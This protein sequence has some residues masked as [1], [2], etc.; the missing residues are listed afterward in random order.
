MIHMK[1]RMNPA[2]IGL[3]AF[4]LAAAGVIALTGPASS[5]VFAS[6]GGGGG[7]SGG[8][9]GGAGGG[10]GS[11]GGG[12]SGGGSGSGH[13]GSGS[14]GGGSA[15]D[16]PMVCKKGSVYS[17]KK[18]TC[19]QASSGLIDDKELY[20]EGRD[21]ALAGHYDEA[22]TALDAVKTPDSMALTMIGY[23][24]RKLGNYEAGLAYYQKA[25][26]LDPGNVNT[27]EYLG[28]AYA[29]KGKLDLAK[30]ELIKVSAVC[31][32]SCEQYEDLAK[33]IDDK[34]AE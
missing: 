4:A 23:A 33:A 32:T 28:E 17:K 27:H 9:G 18:A 13:S 29:E 20:Q 8:G 10:G 16:T 1:R 21:L 30:A 12:S 24:T 3:V 6:G 5:P 25:L 31:G 15:L 11:S 14:S 34:P 26:A 19:V 2:K 22:L 7:H